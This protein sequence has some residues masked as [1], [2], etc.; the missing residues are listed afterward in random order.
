MS[1]LW[2]LVGGLTVAVLGL[3][4]RLGEV[5]ALLGQHEER[6]RA[7]ERLAE[8]AKVSVDYLT[9]DLADLSRRAVAVDPQYVY[10]ESG[11]DEDPADG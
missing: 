6:L 1:I 8:D 11:S 9:E 3:S 4:K 7:V 5:L 10:G 2:A